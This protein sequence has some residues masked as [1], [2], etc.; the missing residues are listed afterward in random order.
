MHEVNKMNEQLNSNV[1]PLILSIQEEDM[2]PP[3]HTQTLYG[4]KYSVNDPTS[5]LY[6]ILYKVKNIEDMN[7]DDFF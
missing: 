3:L 1:S 5:I 7:D 6:Q 4:V 2:L